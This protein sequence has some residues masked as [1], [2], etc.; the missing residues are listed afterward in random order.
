MKLSVFIFA[1]VSA[2]RVA[3]QAEA[4]SNDTAEYEDYGE[5]KRKRYKKKE[6][7]L[8]ASFLHRH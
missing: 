1:A 5:R 2:N 3:R 7:G 6:N 8:T 4:S